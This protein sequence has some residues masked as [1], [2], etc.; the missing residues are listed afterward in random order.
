MD[1]VPL[2][3]HEAHGPAG[4][5]AEGPRLGQLAG[6]ATN[7]GDELGPQTRGGAEGGVQLSRGWRAGRVVERAEGHGSASF[8]LPPIL[9]TVAVDHEVEPQVSR[10]R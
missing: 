8:L 4:L 9:G 3:L 6:V 10:G 7:G 1:E 2:L 5:R